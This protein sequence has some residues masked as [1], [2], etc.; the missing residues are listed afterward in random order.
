MSYADYIFFALTNLVNQSL[1][2]WKP[3]FNAII[4]RGNVV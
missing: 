2:N 1:A 3:A 4:V